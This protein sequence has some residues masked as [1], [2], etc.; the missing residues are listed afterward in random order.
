M[1]GYRL[2]AA[3]GRADRG[4]AERLLGRGA[5]HHHMGALDKAIADYSLAVGLAPDNAQALY[6]R[7]TAYANADDVE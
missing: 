7:G 1:T 2:P 5:A 3:R 4:E 6:N